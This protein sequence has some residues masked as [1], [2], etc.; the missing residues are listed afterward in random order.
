MRM[1]SFWKREHSSLFLQ[2]MSPPLIKI[3]PYLIFYFT[4]NTMETGSNNMTDG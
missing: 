2:N 3:D 4:Y 1:M